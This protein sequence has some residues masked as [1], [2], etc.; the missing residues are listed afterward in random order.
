MPPADVPAHADEPAA[1]PVPQQATIATS[2]SAAIRTCL[3]PFSGPSPRADGLSAFLLSYGIECIDVDS[4]NKRTFAPMDLSVDTAWESYINSTP[5]H[6]A[7]ALGTDCSTFTRCRSNSDSGP[8]V[9]RDKENCYS[10][11]KSYYT[12]MELEK[13][14]L[15]THFAVMSAKLFSEYG[16]FGTW[17]SWR[18]PSLGI[19]QQ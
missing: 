17:S 10:F 7:V 9:L 5:S 13:L 2:A 1:D 6:C 12:L 3:H 15:G 11:E 4:L 14:R 18:S 16:R 8:R 19:R